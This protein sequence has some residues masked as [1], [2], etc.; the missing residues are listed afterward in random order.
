MRKLK[1]ILMAVA[2]IAA[3]SMSSGNVA[4][5][6]GGAG[7]GGRGNF[8]PAQMRQRR[9]DRY[10]EL[11]EVTDDAEWNV[12]SAAIGKVMDAEQAVQSGAIRGGGGGGRQRRGGGADGA[13][14]DANGG[15]GGRQRGGGGFGGTP[16]QEVTDLQAAI[17]AKAPA[18]EIKAKLGKLR[19]ANAANQTKLVAAQDDLK[20]LLTS[21]QEAIAVINGLLK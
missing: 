10:K 3:L 2:C 6:G 21:R 20:K 1:A 4:A 15:G 13:G 5:Q 16:L 12:L 19:D 18:D 17:D 8:D 9:L 14:A 11:F 7:G